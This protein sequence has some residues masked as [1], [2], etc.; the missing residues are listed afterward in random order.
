MTSTATSTLNG[1]Y[2]S[3]SRVSTTTEQGRGRFRAAMGRI[4]RRRFEAARRAH[5]RQELTDAYLDRNGWEGVGVGDL[6]SVYAGR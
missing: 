3:G 1:R 5:E 2:Y 6:L 4:A